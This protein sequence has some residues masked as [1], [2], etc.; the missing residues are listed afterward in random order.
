MA[1]QLSAIIILDGGARP[2]S[3]TEFRVSLVSQNC[4]VSIT[5]TIPVEADLKCTLCKVVLYKSNDKW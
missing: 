2:C 1:E 4:N 5:T 3:F